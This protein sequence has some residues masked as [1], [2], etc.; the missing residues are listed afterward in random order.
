ML[1]Q[2]VMCALKKGAVQPEKSLSLVENVILA[3]FL[4]LFFLQLPQRSAGRLLRCGFSVHSCKAA[5]SSVTRVICTA[6]DIKYRTVTRSDGGE[7]DKGQWCLGTFEGSYVIYWGGFSPFFKILK[8]VFQSVFL[9]KILVDFKFN[10]Q[11]YVAF[12]LFVTIKPDFF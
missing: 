9:W 7:E 5:N 1:H 11:K 3:V 4:F 12:I 6:L 2:C 8:L 10:F